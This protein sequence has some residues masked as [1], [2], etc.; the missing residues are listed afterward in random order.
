M[1]D[2]P[3]AILQICEQKWPKSTGYQMM[4][5]GMPMTKEFWMCQ[6]IEFFKK[7]KHEKEDVIS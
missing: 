7:S 4:M 1:I 6:C 2:A 3:P 5:D